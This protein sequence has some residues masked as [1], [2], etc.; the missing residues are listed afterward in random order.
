MDTRVV[1]R[2]LGPGD[3]HT[4][5]SVDPKVN[6]MCSKCA[7]KIAAMNLSP[8]CSR[9]PTTAMRDSYRAGIVADIIPEPTCGD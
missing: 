2:C 9:Q 5:R 3:E 8:M 4:F 7:A 6:R 1:V